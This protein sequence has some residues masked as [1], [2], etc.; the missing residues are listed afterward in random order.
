MQKLDRQYLG[1][2]I[3]LFNNAGCEVIQMNLLELLLSIASEVV[4]LALMFWAFKKSAILKDQ[5]IPQI[6][7][8]QQ[9]FSLARTQMAFWFLIILLSFLYLFITKASFT[10][11]VTSQALTLMGISVLTAG[12]S[13]IVENVRDT[14]EDALNDGLKALGLSNYQDIVALKQA[15][16]D[17]QDKVN[18]SGLTASEQATLHDKYLLLQTYQNRI[19]PFLTQGWLKDLVTDIDGTALHRL[20][21]FVWTVVLGVIFIYAVYITKAM[22]NFDTNLLALMGISNAGYVGFKYNETQY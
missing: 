18:N 9:T 3:D 15:I 14:P 20:Q 13:A 10:D 5:L 2:K 7:P 16:S 17:L 4:V 11:I 21:A 22:P 12:G 6:S 1:A 19:S 8:N